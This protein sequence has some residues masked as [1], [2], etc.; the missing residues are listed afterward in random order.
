M[1]HL[2]GAQFWKHYQKL[3]K[4][5]QALA[6]KNFVLLKEDPSHPS[7]R[8]KKIDSFYS[9]RVGLKYRALAIE[10]PDG[11]FWFWIG[12]HADYDK[13]LGK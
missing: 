2:A 9:A 5:I 1:K 12:S 8:F 10:V 7:L 4:E 6:D 13:L 3:P 11:L